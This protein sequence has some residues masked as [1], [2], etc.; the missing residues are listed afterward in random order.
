MQAE[1]PETQFRES[2]TLIPFSQGLLTTTHTRHSVPSVPDPVSAPF[3]ANIQTPSQFKGLKLIQLHDP[4]LNHPTPS[5]PATSK[6]HPPQLRHRDGTAAKK[7]EKKS[8]CGSVA[9]NRSHDP[10][11]RRSHPRNPTSEQPEPPEL[12]LH[13]PPLPDHRP[14]LA[15]GLRLLHPQPVQHSGPDVTLPKFHAPAPSRPFSV[16]VPSTTHPPSIKLL[17]V[18]SGPQ[19]VCPLIRFFSF[20]PKGVH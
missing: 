17:H 9:L 3:K 19:P 7:A 5:Q 8:P 10:D 13:L 14:S 1:S 12:S 2:R 11:P 18:D 6:K 4:P 15:Q 16:F 20:Y